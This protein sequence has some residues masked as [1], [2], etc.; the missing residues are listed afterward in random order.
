MTR[1]VVLAGFLLSACSESPV[2]NFEEASP[3]DSGPVDR[4]GEE[5]SEDAGVSSDAGGEPV[6]P[7]PFPLTGCSAV[8]SELPLGMLAVS[9]DGREL[10]GL[11]GDGER[12]V[13]HRSFDE[14]EI[15]EPAVLRGLWAAPGRAIGISVAD[16]D[17]A[18]PVCPRRAELF[19]VE[20]AGVRTFD[21]SAGTRERDPGLGLVTDD[22]LILASVPLRPSFD[23]RRQIA[24][25][26]STGDRYELPSALQWLE[27]GPADM[28]GWRPARLQLSEH[29]DPR[30]GYVHLAGGRTMSVEDAPSDAWH[31]QGRWL[32]LEDGELILAERLDRQRIPLT[33][34]LEDA[35]LGGI[36]GQVVELSRGRSLV[37]VIDLV[38]ERTYVLPTFTSTDSESS[39]QLRI[40]PDV[41]LVSQSG[42]PKARVDLATGRVES[43]ELALP[44]S[45]ETIQAAYCTPALHP[46]V[47]GGYVLALRTPEHTGAFRHQNGVL[48]PVGRPVR[49]VSWVSVVPAGPTLAVSSNTGLRTFCPHVEPSEEPP[50]GEEL[51]GDSIQLVNAQGDVYVLEE[52]SRLTFLDP[53]G[54]CA[55]ASSQAPP[56][57][58]VLIDLVNGAEVEWQSDAYWLAPFSLALPL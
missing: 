26:L 53:S 45:H 16:E 28:E 51:V 2:S 33:D 21:V 4:G 57:A 8:A 7:G 30:P 36:R 48:E 49:D 42:L 13:L 52:G 50:V 10:I 14:V 47:D 9:F 40:G 54:R 58:H 41:V 43:L 6:D 29:G 56:G 22:G 27:R 46:M 3:P 17:C 18:D 34:S 12:R 15:L 19:V 23:D 1:L 32:W 37:G 25:D 35:R 55:M 31:W 20:A 11:R 44:P 39:F 24:I 38:R 5:G